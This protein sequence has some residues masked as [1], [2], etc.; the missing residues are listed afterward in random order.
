[1]WEEI[2][3]ELLNCPR[4]EYLTFVRRN[5]SI[6]FWHLQAFYRIEGLYQRL[7]FCEYISLRKEEYNKTGIERQ[8]VQPVF[9]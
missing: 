2:L 3:T 8:T 5:M 9:I 7:H 6:L 4:A 1:M